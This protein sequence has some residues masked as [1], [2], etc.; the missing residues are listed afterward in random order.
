MDPSQEGQRE[1]SYQACEGPSATL[2][3]GVQVVRRVPVVV[4]LRFDLHGLNL[5]GGKLLFELGYICFKLLELHLLSR[6]SCSC[7]VDGGA[8]RS[9][10]FLLLLA[11]F[12]C[13]GLRSFVRNYVGGFDGHSRSILNFRLPV[14]VLLHILMEITDKD[15]ENLLLKIGFVLG[16]DFLFPELGELVAFAGLELYRGG[17][18]HKLI[19]EDFLEVLK[20]LHLQL[21]FDLDIAPRRDDALDGFHH[22][23]FRSRCLNFI[24]NILFSIDILNVEGGSRHVLA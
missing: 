2:L 21:N 6:G 24:S 11:R 20:L 3:V 10:V 16:C 1:Y 17:L 7:G 9:F 13:L 23:Q 8:W 22:E 18:N 12:L 5:H 19:L 15:L 14:K 4:L